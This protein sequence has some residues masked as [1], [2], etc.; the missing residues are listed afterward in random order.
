M[1]LRQGLS[2]AR[3]GRA[4]GPA[5][6]RLRAQALI[7]WQEGPKERRPCALSG[8]RCIG[9]QLDSNLIENHCIQQQKWRSR[10]I[11]CAR[12][13]APWILVSSEPDEETG[14]LA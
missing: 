6:G 10:A 7:A 13:S 5:Q 1:G 3:C 2:C 14:L 12:T 4:S 8:V 9:I 11:S